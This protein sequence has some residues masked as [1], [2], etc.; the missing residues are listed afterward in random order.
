MQ[1]SL[2]DLDKAYKNYFERRKNGTLPKSQKRRKDRMPP[3]YPRYKSRHD[4]QSIRYPQRVKVNGNRIYLPKVG[5][6]R[7]V[8]HRPIEGEIENVTVSKTKSGKYFISIQCEVEITEPTY[9]GPE[10]G[11]DLGLKDFA[12]LSTSER[13]P[14]PKHLCKAEKKLRRLQRTLSR[15]EKGSKGQEKA[16][17]ALARQHEKVANQRADFLNKLSRRMV[18]EAGYIKIENLNV[19]GMLRNHSLA[20]SISDSGWGMFGRMLVYKGEWY[21]SW[22]EH[23]DRFYPSSRLCHVC[24]YR[25]D[26]LELTDRFWTCPAC[27]TEH[28]RDVNAARNIRDFK[29]TAGTAETNAGGENVSPVPAPAGTGRL[30]ETGSPLAFSSG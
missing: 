13:V 4:K 15:R 12:V 23:I 6:V 9:A 22:V 2:R 1:Q 20:K 21:G 3:G 8:F 18:D 29:S 14:H 24:N 26:E 16:R 19:C 10:L 11:I 17:L 28:D 5:H 27:G 30:N 7:T 25:N